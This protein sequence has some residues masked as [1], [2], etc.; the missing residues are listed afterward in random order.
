MRRIFLTIVLFLGALTPLTAAP[1]T[2]A[3]FY[4]EGLGPIDIP[5]EGFH[6][7]TDVPVLLRVVDC[8]VI[9]DQFEVFS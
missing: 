4:W 5:G 8:C 7:T 3:P 1:G 2:W 6:F 9:G